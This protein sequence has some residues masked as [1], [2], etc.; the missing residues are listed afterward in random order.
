MGLLKAR[1]KLVPRDDILVDK[2]VQDD[3]ANAHL[4]SKELGE[5]SVHD[6]PR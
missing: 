4:P 3:G 1:T 5:F 2:Y 6:W